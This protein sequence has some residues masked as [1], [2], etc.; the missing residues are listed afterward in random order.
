MLANVTLHNVIISN[1]VTLSHYPQREFNIICNT[2]M[3]Y[4][5][6]IV[7]YCSLTKLFINKLRIKIKMNAMSYTGKTY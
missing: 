4:D 6:Y 3:V 5:R 1:Y 2:N 7:Y